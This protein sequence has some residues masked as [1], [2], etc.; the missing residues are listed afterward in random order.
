ESGDASACE[1][2]AVAQAYAEEHWGRVIEEHIAADQALS[3]DP[4]SEGALAAHDDSAGL[5]LGARVEVILAEAETWQ[6]CR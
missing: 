5:L 3:S 4:A 2:A 1:Q 6:S